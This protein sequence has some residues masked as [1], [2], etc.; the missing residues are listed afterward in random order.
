VGLPLPVDR[1]AHLFLFRPFGQKEE[2]QA[3]RVFQEGGGGHLLPVLEGPEEAGFVG[4]KGLE[5]LRREVGGEKE[6]VLLP[7]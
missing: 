6:A 4:A 3:A 1:K 2:G 5:G 7:G